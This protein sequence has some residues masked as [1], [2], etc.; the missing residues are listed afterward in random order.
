[1]MGFFFHPGPVV[2]FADAKKASQERFVRFFRA[3]LE[4][5]IYLAPSAFEAGFISLAHGPAD[6]DQ[7]LEVAK[8]AFAAAAAV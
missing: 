8:G 1:M 5:G 2:N 3:M 4:G 7:T 6:I